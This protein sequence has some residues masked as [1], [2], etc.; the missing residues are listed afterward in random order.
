MV[1]QPQPPAADGI[2]LI[3]A[4]AAAANVGGVQP[5]EDS[6]PPPP[7]L[8]SAYVAEEQ[9]LG[10]HMHLPARMPEPGVASGS[11]YSEMAA[12]GELLPFA[13]VATNQEVVSSMLYDC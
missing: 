2:A 5:Q 8:A 10:H 12:A 9:H 7:H 6:I 11:G 4:A 13:R 3:A 1:Q